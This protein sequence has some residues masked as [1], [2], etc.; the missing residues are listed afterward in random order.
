MT[1]LQTY[2][3]ELRPCLREPLVTEEALAAL[4]ARAGAQT[5]PF[6]AFYLECR[7]SPPGPSL[8]LLAGAFHGKQH[9]LAP[10]PRRIALDPVGR[11]HEFVVSWL[12]GARQRAAFKSLW[13]ELDDAAGVPSPFANLHLCVDPG[14]AAAPPDPRV[15]RRPAAFD[16][17][18][19]TRL[20][21][22]LTAERVLSPKQL[23]LLELCLS[24]LPPGGRLVHVS[25]MT[26]RAPIQTKAY[27]ALP[28]GTLRDYVSRVGCALQPAQLD[29]LT[30]W[31]E[32]SLTGSTIYCDV[33]FRGSVCES[34]GIV[35]SQPQIAE[36]DS[37]TARRSLRDRLL[38]EGLSTLAQDA[39]LGAWT[40]P[41]LLHVSA[42]NPDCRLV[43]WLDLKI[44]IRASGL[45]AKAYLGFAPR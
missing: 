3:E 1:T 25:T 33:T 40:L 31:L 4:A 13:V 12:A 39:A 20:L 5:L 29:A 37:D 17:G 38:R 6:G 41:P 21:D 44:T 35:F 34:I 9:E 15:P 19:A 11:T 30:P 14:Y 18:T 42:K 2:L 7:L 45:S 22:E 27:A 28:T 36:V 24:A 8:D 10:E 43:R 23:T 16:A 26:A 32:P